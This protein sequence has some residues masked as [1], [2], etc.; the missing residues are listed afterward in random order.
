M[1][2]LGEI[3]A[4]GAAERGEGAPALFRIEAAGRTAD[5][6]A[7]ACKA[8]IDAARSGGGPDNIAV[9]VVRLT[10]QSLRLPE[11]LELTP[12]PRSLEAPPAEI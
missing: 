8:L 7:G 11:P 10:G 12:T 2:D 1:I 9:A 3:R 5:D 6:A 4:H